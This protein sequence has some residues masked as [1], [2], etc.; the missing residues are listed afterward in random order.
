[1]FRRG[2]P[3]WRDVFGVCDNHP[4]LPVVLMEVQGRNNRTMYALLER[5]EN[6]Y[7]Q[8]GGLTVHEGIED[9]CRRFGAERLVF[10]SGFPEKTLG[11]ARLHVERARI[12]EPERRLVAAGN[13]E[14]LLAAID[15]REAH[16][17]AD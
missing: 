14:R 16:A 9:I 8:T 13:L 3:P 2:E 6:L 10:G 11:A 5:F 12:S 15:R 7:L 4:D 17:H 1:L